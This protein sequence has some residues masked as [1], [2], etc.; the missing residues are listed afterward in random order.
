M[1]DNRRPVSRPHTGASRARRTIDVAREDASSLH[2]YAR[3]PIAFEVREIAEPTRTFGAEP[4]SFRRRVVRVPW[5]KDYDVDGGPLAWPSRFDLSRW[6]FF[7][8]R[9]DGVRVGGAA[10]VFGA[11]DV[12]ML[13]GQNDVAL[14]WDVRVHPQA[15]GRGVGAALV[16][17]AERWS[18]AEGASWLEVE[19]QNV[20]APACRFYE[21]QGFVLRE[22]NPGAY[23]TLPSEVQLLWYKAISAEER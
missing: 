9:V 8:A 15:R 22:V 7:A 3:V 10:V 4:F 20:N 17:A 2:E 1:A 19:T 11:L 23:P 16:A 5:I 13:A 6:A 18:V 12:E 21:R 14:L